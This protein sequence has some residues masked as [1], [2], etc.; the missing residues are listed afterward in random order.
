[1]LAQDVLTFITWG[2]GGL[3]R[4][5]MGKIRHQLSALQTVNISP[6]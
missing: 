2:G 4:K 6:L 3:S 5:G 1:M